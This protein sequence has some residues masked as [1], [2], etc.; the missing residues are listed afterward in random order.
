MGLLKRIENSETTV[1]DASKLRGIL[2]L[3]ISIILLLLVAF[4]ALVLGALVIK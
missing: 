4:G 1:N 3:L 2:F